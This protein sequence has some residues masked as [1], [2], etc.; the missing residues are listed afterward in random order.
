MSFGTTCVCTDLIYR[1]PFPALA[2]SP[3]GTGIVLLGRKIPSF[4]SGL[5]GSRIH[6][7]KQTCHRARRSRAADAQKRFGLKP[8]ALRQ[9]PSSGQ[10]APIKPQRN[11][12][13]YVNCNWQANGFMLEKSMKKA[14]NQ[15]G[16]RAD[17]MSPVVKAQDAFPA[18]LPIVVN[19]ALHPEAI[20]HHSLNLLRCHSLMR[21]VQAGRVTLRS[22]YASSTGTSASLGGRQYAPLG[23]R[24]A[25]TP[26][27]V[28]DAGP[29]AASKRRRSCFLCFRMFEATGVRV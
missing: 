26:V 10:T 7:F 29:A 19:A 25:A 17:T 13:R 27:S 16:S 11:S 22:F 1:H 23:R 3:S 28:G 21:P 2:N 12:S 20:W 24:F 4:V 9:G 14:E 8:D 6:I 18:P 5:L 15:E